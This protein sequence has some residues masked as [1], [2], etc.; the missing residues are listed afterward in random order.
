[1]NITVTE[2]APPVV[3]TPAV[4]HRNVPKISA[5]DVAEQTL[6]AASKGAKEVYPGQARWL[7]LM[8]RVVPS[9]AEELVAKS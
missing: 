8:L 5:K 1:L 9:F 6:S 4:A 3:D 2:V 7:P